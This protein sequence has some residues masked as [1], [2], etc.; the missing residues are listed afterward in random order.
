MLSTAGI[1]TPPATFSTPAASTR[2]DS[3]SS[4]GEG[5][6]SETF[7]YLNISLHESRCCFSSLSSDL[8]L[9]KKYEIFRG[10][11]KCVALGGQRVRERERKRFKVAISQQTCVCV[12][13]RRLEKFF[14]PSFFSF[15]SLS[16]SLAFANRLERQMSSSG[17]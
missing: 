17:D 10:Q 6:S 5:S 16:L 15:S 9:V 12:C 8:K 4:G 1:E 3:S 14:A 11:Y 2:E 13:E 7:L